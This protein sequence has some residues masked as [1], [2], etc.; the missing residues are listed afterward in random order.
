MKS[1]T[2]S[3]IA[4]SLLPLTAWAAE[5]L[6]VGDEIVIMPAGDGTGIRGT[7][8]LA[9]GGNGYLAVWREGWHGE[10]GVA[11]IYA[12]RLDEAGKA[13]DPKGIE[14][15]PSK[16]GM[17]ELPRIAFGGG[18]FLVVWQDDR[19][20]KD[21]DVL[22]ARIAPDGKVLD[23]QPIAI[24][25]G[26]RTQ[27]APDVT[28]NGQEFLVAWQSVDG[29]EN[30][31]HVET[32]RVGA[33]GRVSAPAR[34]QSPWTKAG[35]SPR[36]AWDGTNYRL[37][38]LSQS[39][40][41]V[42]LKP[43]GSLPQKEQFTTLRGNLGAGIGFWHSITAS[44]DK[45]LLAVF[46]RSQPD[47]WGWGG[48]GAVICCLVGMDNKVDSTIPKEDYPQK[49]LPNWLDFGRDRK[50]GSPWPYGQCDV[51]WDGRQFVAVWQRQH[52]QKTVSF[53]NCDLI[54]SRVDGWKPL[55]PDGVSVA[56]SELEEKSPALAS[57]GNGKLLCGY[58]RHDGDGNISIVARLLSTR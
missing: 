18:V 51:A 39:L 41:S 20:G 50:E 3:M 38:F 24:G 15:A 29:A 30:L 14:I 33:D 35:A 26:P 57:D 1:M 28:S 27:C 12:A 52:I 11:R 8:H 6:Q 7:P 23:A 47:Y 4:I 34:I 43:D 46:P 32:A 36:V 37:V 31:F 49:K 44:P 21:C 40:L 16:D 55:D 53:G 56:A 2:V 19:N 25:A 10:G 5:G 48:P 42:R 22:G 9:H 45:G 54:A 58:E 13:L 17:Q